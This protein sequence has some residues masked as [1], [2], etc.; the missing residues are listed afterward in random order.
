MGIGAYVTALLW[1]HFRLSPWIGIPLALVA[2][3]ALA[4]LVAYPCFRFRIIGHYF[5][6]VTL[7]LSRH[8]A[9][10]DHRHARLHRR[11]ARLHAG[12]LPGRQLALRAAVHRQDD[13]VPDRAR[14]VGGG[15]VLWHRVDRSMLRYALEAIAED[16]DAAAA[17]G[18][19]V[20][21]GEAQDHRAERGDD[22]AR[23]RALLPVPDVH[24]ARH[25]ERHLGVAADGVRGGGRRDLR[26]RSARRSAR[27]SRSCWPRCCA[28]ASAPARSAG[29]TSS[30]ACCSWCS[31]SSCRRASWGAC[32][33]YGVGRPDRTPRGSPRRAAP[34]PSRAARLSGRP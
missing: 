3:G 32:R 14:R 23:R 9:A 8:R 1:N 22:R 11:L 13:L 34:P 28:S 5:A 17:A 19:H 10:G 2:G 15:P 6:L 21:C 16:E 25:G 31:S 20:T 7:A 24:L 27:S 29:T 18:V 33:G 30:T 4:V 26:A 12:A